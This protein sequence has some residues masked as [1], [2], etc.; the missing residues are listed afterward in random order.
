M[1]RNPLNEIDGNT[2]L[3]PIDEPDTYH[4]PICEK[5]VPEDECNSKRQVCY[6]CWW[7]I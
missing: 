4:C 1:S 2:L 7:K 3:I 6:N 5:D